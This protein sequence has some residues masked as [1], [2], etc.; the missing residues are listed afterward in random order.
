MTIREKGYSGWDGELRRGRGRWLPIFRQGI[1]SVFRKK[2]AK[3]VFALCSS[4]FVVFLAAIYIA[5]KPELKMMAE[6]VRM[7]SS[8]AAIFNT[9]YTNGFHF[10]MLIILSL[11]SGAELIADDLKFKSFSLYFARPLR[12]VDYLLGK[13]SIVY[14]YLL[15]FTLAPGVLLVLAKIIFAGS[16]SLQPRLLA[17]ILLFPL[18]AALTMSLLALAVSSLSTSSKLTRVFIFLVYMFGNSLAEILK[19]VFGSDWFYLFSLQKTVEQLGVFFFGSKTGW[20]YPP[21]VAAAEMLLLSA[22]FAFILM[23][24][25]RIAEA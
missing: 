13:L 9:F 17:G 16:F 8:D 19:H 15:L 2:Y 12:K 3:L 6:L 7:F 11:F 24:R 5:T 20:A 22:L 23:R 1:R 25:V 21:W 4:T 10:W 18:L 14:F